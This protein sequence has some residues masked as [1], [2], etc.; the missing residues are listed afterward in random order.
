MSC[1][2]LRFAVAD[3]ATAG[4]FRLAMTYPSFDVIQPSAITASRPRPDIRK[5]SG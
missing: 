2:E 4:N 3:V 1:D 5:R